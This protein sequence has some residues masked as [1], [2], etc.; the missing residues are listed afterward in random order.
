MPKSFR[1][2]SVRFSSCLLALT[3]V[4]TQAIPQASVHAGDSGRERIKEVQPRPSGGVLSKTELDSR[5]FDTLEGPH[6]ALVPY[7]DFSLQTHAEQPGAFAAIAGAVDRAVDMLPGEPDFAFAMPAAAVYEAIQRRQPALFAQMRLRFEQDR[8]EIVGGRWCQADT[9]LVCEE[10]NARQFLYGQRFF[11]DTFGVS[12]SVGWEPSTPGY[13]AAFPQLLKLAG[14]ERLYLSCDAVDAPVFWWESPDGSRVL[15]INRAA[16]GSWP[17]VTALHEGEAGK[18][19]FTSSGDVFGRIMNDSTITIPS[20]RGPL[21]SSETGRFST[22]AHIKRLNRQAESSLVTAEAIASVASLFG[23]AYP[24]TDLRDL[25][26]EL[27]WHQHHETLGGLCIDDSYDYSKVVLDA[28]IAKGAWITRSAMRHLA[29]LVPNEGPGYGVLVG[30]PLGFSRSGPVAA[31]VPPKSTRMSR[32]RVTRGDGKEVGWQI[33]RRAGGMALMFWAQEVP[34]FGYDVYRVEELPPLEQ[35]KPHEA[36][37]GLDKAECRV[38]EGGVL[39]ENGWVRV[40]IDSTTGRLSSVFDKATGRELL[41]PNQ[42]GNTFEIHLEDASARNAAKLGK[43]VDIQTVD[44]RAD[45]TLTELRP[46]QAR[47]RLT[48]RFANSSI[49]QY[50]VLTA[51]S[52]RIDFETIIRW[53]EQA[54]DDKPAPMLRVAFPLAVSDETLFRYST[55]F[56]S[57]VGERGVSEVAAGSFAALVGPEGGAALLND[58]THGCSA[59]PD[60][61]VRLTLLRCGREADLTA[62][63]YTHTLTY[64]LLPVGPEVSPSELA[65]A[66]MAL[67]YPF[68]IYRLPEVNSPAVANSPTSIPGRYGAFDVSNLKSIVP[69]CLKGSEDRTG[70]VM[71]FY[72]DSPLNDVGLMWANFPV[73]EAFEVNLL[74]DL[75]RAA[76]FE[77]RGDRAGFP[78]GLK[79]HEIRTYRIRP[80]GDNWWTGLAD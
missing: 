73:A 24:T 13:P 60:G 69:T 48:W 49:Y 71:R 16:S 30:N 15:A 80:T 18:M 2:S 33:V 14:I 51:G 76:A 44:D 72:Q 6:G 12:A 50:V 79:G 27:G 65:R 68:V 52:P 31:A 46:F 62:D 55:P 75:V 26:R 29:G 35:P 4:A 21:P 3:F 32:Y 66:D 56:A 63:R 11:R 54:A 37:S 41:A 61:V 39:M 17:D 67:N 20:R 28:V 74:E 19:R 40:M 43:I 25:W 64:S 57:A 42:M 53:R 36:I 23:F 70:L 38:V 58:S 45:T 77:Q 22:N 7:A 34:A 59:S 1:L 78:V 9:Q 10:S 47:V 8:L 5:V